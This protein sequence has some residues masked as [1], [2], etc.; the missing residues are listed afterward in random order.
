MGKR[1]RF[2]ALFTSGATGLASSREN[3]RPPAQQTSFTLSPSSNAP[4]PSTNAPPSPNA[5]HGGV[6]APTAPRK[7]VLEK[8]V[9]EY[10]KKI[11]EAEKAAF[12]QMSK[13]L[14]DQTLISNVRA[15]DV[16]HKD[17]SSFRPHAE[18]L[19]KFLNLLN[20]FMGGVAIG[21]QASPEISSL[22]VG[23]VR[24]VIDLALTFTIFFSKLTDMVCTFEDYLGPLAEYARTKRIEL[25]EKAVVSIY[26]NILDFGWKA[27]YVFIDKNGDQR[28]WTSFRMFLRQQWETFESEFVSI[29]ENIQHHFY[30]LQLSVQALQFDAEQS[31]KRE[32]ESKLTLSTVTCVNILFLLFRE[33]KVGVPLLG[34]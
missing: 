2:K 34:I 33:R 30:V 17:N 8:A 6:L 15:Y 23:A 7:T 29:K 19:E 24:I 22:V 9:T 12:A 4:T 5:P 28:R 32:E 31:R 14:D 11:P 10:L 13:S 3:P 21:I 20:R 16:A 25:V 18:R 27:R 26:V 1:D